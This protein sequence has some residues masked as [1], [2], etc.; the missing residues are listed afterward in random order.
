MQFIRPNSTEQNHPSD[1]VST[2][3]SRTDAGTY[4]LPKPPQQ[5]KVHVNVT[6]FTP[7][8][9]CLPVH[10]SVV[11]STHSVCLPKALIVLR[12]SSGCLNS[13]RL[14]KRTRDG[15]DGVGH[16]EGGPASCPAP[17]NH[18]PSISSQRGVFPFRYNLSH[19]RFNVSVLGEEEF[20]QLGKMNNSAMKTLILKV[21]ALECLRAKEKSKNAVIQLDHNGGV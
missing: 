6:V 15:C 17:V 1:R 8:S 21:F 14:S 9:D 7:S 11:F 3:N 20:R 12:H 18:A 16:C 2:E 19:A 5:Y 4:Q 10:P 13:F